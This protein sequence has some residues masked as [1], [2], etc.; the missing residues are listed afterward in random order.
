MERLATEFNQKPVVVNAFPDGK[1]ENSQGFVEVSNP[2]VTLVAMKKSQQSEGYV[3]RFLNNSSQQARSTVYVLGTEITLT[4]GKYE[5]K[6]LLYREGRL[7]EVAE[8]LI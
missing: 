3:L 4:F 2:N 7:E 5:V 6:T 8:M 1:G